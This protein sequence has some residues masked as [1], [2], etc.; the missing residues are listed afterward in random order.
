MSLYA[1][2]SKA[3][4]AKIQVYLFFVFLAIRYAWRSLNCTHGLR[5]A[6]FDAV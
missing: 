6:T 2:H 1:V 4:R 5:F 3:E